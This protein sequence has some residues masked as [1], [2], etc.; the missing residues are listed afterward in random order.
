MKLLDLCH[1]IL[2]HFLIVVLLLIN[3][4]KQAFAENLVGVFVQTVVAEKRVWI[5]DVGSFA[6]STTHI[7]KLYA[8]ELVVGNAIP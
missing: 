5:A 1:Q 7:C 4:L 3:N 2:F 6:D 8:L